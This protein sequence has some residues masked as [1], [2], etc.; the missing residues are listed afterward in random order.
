MTLEFMLPLSPSLKG[1]KRETK[2]QA[3]K[4]VKVFISVKENFL[5]YHQVLRY[6][7]GSR[8]FRSNN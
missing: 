4:Q 3:P 6:W 8:G 7:L 2:G 5:K 1:V